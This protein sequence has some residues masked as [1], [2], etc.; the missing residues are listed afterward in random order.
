[1]SFLIA[2]RKLRAREILLVILWALVLVP[3]LLLV[4]IPTSTAVQGVL[5]IFAVIVVA[6]LKPWT[7]K[8]IVVRFL[9]LAV[10]SVV[11]MRYW[12]WRLT[13]T[14]PPVDAPISFIAAALLFMVETYAIG[15]FFISSFI[16]ADPVKR[17]LPPKVAVTDLPTVDILVPSY[18]EPIEMLSITLS[19]ARNMHY[20][21]EKR[22][23]VL[24]DDGGTD[25]RCNSDDPE[26]AEA[27][28]K[29]RRDLQALCRELGVVYS[30]R[31]R[32][33]HA[34]AGNMSA[35]LERLDGDLVVVFDAD[36]VP[37]RD[38]LARTVGYFVED[39]K[40]FLVQTPH[41]FLN[42]DPIDRNI[43]LRADCPPENEMFYHQGHRGLDRWGGAFFCGSAAVIR[44]AALDDVGGF[45]GETITEDAETALEI[46]SRGWKSLYVDHAM[47]AGLQPETFTTFI[48][49]RGR[50]AAGMMQLLRLKNPLRRKGLSLTQ[51]LCYLNSMTFWLFPLVRMAFI[52]AP[53]AYLFFGLQIF[54]ATFQ[55][56]MVYMS[57]YMLVSF[58]VQ[59]AL[60]ARV[61]WPLISELYE[62]A[63]APYLSGV[64]LRTLFKPRGAQF[65]VTA[66]D[67]VLD[68]D[69]ITPI[70][71]PL[72]I[73]WALAGLGVIAA[74]IRWMLFPGD[75]TILMV[76]GGWAIFNFLILS[77]ALRV[78]AE[79]MQRRASPR[80]PME[81]PAI[82]AIGREDYAFVKATVV[83]ASTSGARLLLQPATEEDRREL[84]ALVEGQVFY[85]TPEFPRSPHL[86]N[87]VR[88]QVKTVDKDAKGFVVGVR[89]D[90]D[91]PMAVR[92]TVAH[93]IFG[94]SAVW[95]NIRAGRSKPKPMTVGMLYV[96]GLAVTSVYHTMRALAAEPA[97]RRRARADERAAERERAVPAH[98]LAFGET[99][100]PEPGPSATR[101]P[102]D[103]A[104]RRSDAG[105]PVTGG[106]PIPVPVAP[107]GGEGWRPA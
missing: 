56:V 33:E 40:L 96:L 86:E 93:L 92:E 74:G 45:A 62:T 4:S 30:T 46:H 61:R 19:A 47:I 63:Q 104:A 102:F 89:Y 13:E 7:M 70:Y 76:V 16:T 22:T 44:R 14:L 82:A 57:S 27:A 60:Y 107:Q 59:N 37:S 77:A 42:P 98:L 34:K 69:V 20:P 11:V 97:R 2:T 55:E 24:C 94:D 75:H 21:P 15:V 79:R 39:P 87:A 32:N 90:P 103:P 23:V 66:K 8:N 81:A 99:F 64:V 88:V 50:W 95:E 65:K 48:E 35:A 106:Q 105:H 36:H 101:I 58:M 12:S 100:D 10:A 1:M 17:S 29:R 84:A 25:Q 91:Q 80:V 85:F 49:Q 38:F 6:A 73:V 67:E 43:G 53:L 72:L 51:R 31:E 68:E 18:N 28:R 9:L 41:F 26:L 71:Q 5:G 78:I 54:V 3:I 52:L 83:N